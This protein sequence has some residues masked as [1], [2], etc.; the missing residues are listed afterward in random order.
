VK[1]ALRLSALAILAAATLAGC[2]RFTSDT[3]VHADDTFSQT[4]IIATTEAARSQ[5]G[6]MVPVDLGDL[7]GAISSS[8]GYLELVAEYPEQIAIEDYS[9]GDLSGVKLTATNLPLDEFER[10][11]SQLTAQLPFTANATI[12]HTEE[13]YVVSLPA[14]SAAGAL[15]QAGISAGQ[16][17]LLGTSVDVSISFSF[18]GLV[19]SAT[20]GEVEGKTVTLGL[21]DLASGQD[22][23]IVAGAAEQIDWQP[24]LMWGGIGLAALVIIGGATALIVQDVKR[25][26]HN[27][28]PPPDAAAGQAASGPGILVTE[29]QPKATDAEASEGDKPH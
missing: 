7:K 16:L 5:L 22:I 15:E 27:A 28:L 25:H 6:S 11:F 2:V 18:P 12:A 4:A 24:W 26:R 29:E 13:T 17:E 21:A 10:S 20:A 14:G 9:D 8:E 23:T 3:A 19:T 1:A